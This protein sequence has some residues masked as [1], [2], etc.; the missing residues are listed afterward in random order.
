[1]NNSMPVVFV[2][3]GNVGVGIQQLAFFLF[4]FRM[5]CMRSPFMLFALTAFTPFTHNWRNSNSVPLIIGTSATQTFLFAARGKAPG[6]TS[7]IFQLIIFIPPLNIGR[8]FYVL[9]IYVGLSF[10][11]ASSARR[12]IVSE[13]GYQPPFIKM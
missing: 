6:A 7:D 2:N 1:M 5:R 11:P 13:I 12:I 4:Q 10:V 9:S 8:S 3:K